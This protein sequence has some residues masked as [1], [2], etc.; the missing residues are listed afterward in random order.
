MDYKV[1]IV[2]SKEDN[3]NAQYIYNCLTRIVELIP[4]KA[5]LYKAYGEN[6]KQ[7][8]QREL[9][10]SYFMVVLLTENGKNSQWV[11]QEIGYAYALQQRRQ[12][13]YAGLPIIIPISHKQVKLKGFITKDTIDFLILDN[14]PSFEYVIA[15]L[16]PQIRMRIPKGLK[17]GVLHFRITCF[18]CF[19]ERGFSYEWVST[20][21]DQHEM[22]KAF[23]S[24][25]YWLQYT[26]PK[27]KGLNSVDVRN[28]LSE[29]PTEE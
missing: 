20:L 15:D 6:F 24:G 4:Y 14:Y 11:N 25:K 8:L 12:R 23:Q 5:E 3:G 13:Q 7:R 1:F 16:I 9:A 28:F 18:N 17:E 22:A 29:K 19:D 10:E 21:P 26:C 27:C 2:Y